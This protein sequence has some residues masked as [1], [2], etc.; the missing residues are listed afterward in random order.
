MGFS[1]FGAALLTSVSLLLLRRD[2]GRAE[3]KSEALSRLT[4]GS[5]CS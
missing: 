3:K 5:R 2:L 4:G 1:P